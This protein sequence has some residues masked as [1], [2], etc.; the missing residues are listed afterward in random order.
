MLSEDV[1]EKGYALLCVAIPQSDCKLTT[2]SEVRCMTAL[3]AMRPA[4]SPFIIS[5]KRSPP[6]VIW[7]GLN[8]PLVPALDQFYFRFCTT[9]MLMFFC[10]CISLSTPILIWLHLFRRNS[11]SSSLGEAKNATKCVWS[12]HVEPLLFLFLG[13]A[14]QLISTSWGSILI[15]ACKYSMSLFKILFHSPFLSQPCLSCCKVN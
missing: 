13:Q 12:Q 5:L 15:V 14:Q 10:C 7:F 6:G 2:I 4:T 11:W 3:H 8:G 1:A 9:N